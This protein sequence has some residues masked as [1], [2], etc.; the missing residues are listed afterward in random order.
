MALEQRPLECQRL[1]KCHVVA[2]NRRKWLRQKFRSRRIIMNDLR[3]DYVWVY[4][5]LG[6]SVC[7]AAASD[8]LLRPRLAL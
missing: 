2:S 6:Q 8:G 3:A 1:H 5:P 7:L 4:D